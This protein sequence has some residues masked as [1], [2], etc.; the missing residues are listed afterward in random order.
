MIH[1]KTTVHMT[2]KIAIF[3]YYKTSAPHRIDGSLR[4]MTTYFSTRFEDNH[5]YCFGNGWCGKEAIIKKNHSVKDY[6]KVDF[7]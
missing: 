7:I 4:E 1:V 5:I 3:K 6:R 2:A